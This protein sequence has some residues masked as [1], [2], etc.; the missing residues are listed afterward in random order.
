MLARALLIALVAEVLGFGLLA[1]DWASGQMLVAACLLL[2][3]LVLFWIGCSLTLTL[4]TYAIARYSVPR[5][6]AISWPPARV[7]LGE[8]L[9]SILLFVVLQAFTRW[10]LP[11]NVPRQRNGPRPRVLFIHGYFCN[12]GLW[13]FH[14][15]ALEARGFQCT[16]IDLEPPWG[17]I[18]RFAQQV[19][20]QLD[21]MRSKAPEASIV[22]VAHSMGGLVARAALTGSGAMNVAKVV[23]L[24][25]PH[26]GTKLAHWGVGQC[27]RQMQ[28]DGPWLKALTDV[29]SLDVPFVS[30]WSQHDNFMAP[31]DTPL[32]PGSRTVALRGLGHLSLALSIEVQQLLIDELEAVSARALPAP[33]DQMRMPRNS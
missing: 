28:P 26:R 14:R 30:L 7:L 21:A 16:S 29:P 15:L 1:W 4:A 24:G 23:T 11:T 22:L 3:L 2:G 13:L 27:A 5:S 12:S 18:D 6:R 25:T 19:A 31:A 10:L 8:V 9:A 17:S 33:E 20:Q 32:L